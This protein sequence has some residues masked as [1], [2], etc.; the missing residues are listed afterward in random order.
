VMPSAPNARPHAAK[1]GLV[2]FI[3][4]MNLRSG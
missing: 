1:S 4:S 3:V 2:N